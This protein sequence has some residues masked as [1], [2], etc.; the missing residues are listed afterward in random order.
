VVEENKEVCQ[1]PGFEMKKPQ[2]YYYKDPP[3]KSFIKAAQYKKI[4]H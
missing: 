3:I 2:R 4:K 1:L